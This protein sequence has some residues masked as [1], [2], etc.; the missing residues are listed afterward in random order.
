MTVT[1]R[2]DGI[3]YSD[4]TLQT[5]AATTFNAATTTTRGVGYSAGNIPAYQ[6]GAAMTTLFAVTQSRTF[7][8]GRGQYWRNMIGSR[9]T[10]VTYYNTTK[11][12]MAVAVTTG[13]TGDWTNVSI[14]VNG[15][16]ACAQGG[17]QQAGFGG[18]NVNATA[19]VPPGASYSVTS[20]TGISYWAELY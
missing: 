19:I 14:I 13:K 7:G 5:T 12:G 20:T 8:P 9:T 16:T 15:V 4:G 1:V 3:L 18:S 2:S 11:R 6:T 10:G 17:D